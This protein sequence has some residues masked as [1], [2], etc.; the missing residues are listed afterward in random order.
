M[1][2]YRRLYKGVYVWAEAAAAARAEEDARR[3]QQRLLDEAKRA[4]A[5]NAEQGELPQPTRFEV[6]SML[7]TYL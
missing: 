7:C 1:F 5:H 2:I 3:E 4:A 6:F